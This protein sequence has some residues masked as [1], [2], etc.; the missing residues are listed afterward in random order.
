[1]TGLEADGAAVRTVFL[2]SGPFAV[3]ILDVLVDHRS[4]DLV[5]IVTSPPRPA[6]RRRTPT[7]TAVDLRARSLDLGPIL[8]PDRLRELDSVDDVLS[9]EPGLAVLADYGQLVPGALLRLSHGALNLHPS[10]LPRH[11]G[12]SP[13]PA[14]ILEGDRQTGVSLMLMDEDLDTGPILAQEVVPLTGT[15]TAPDLERTLAD[16]A[17]VLLAERL[18][19]WLRGEI[20]PAPQSDVGSTLTRPLRREDGRLD[21]TRP[22][23]RLERQ[24]RAYRPWPGS[25]VDSIAGRIGVWEAA[26]IEAAAEAR[27]GRL[28]RDGMTAGDGRRLRFLTVQP[29]GGRRMTW[30]ELLR[31]RPMLVGSDVVSG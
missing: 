22:A 2:G 16:V 7:P 28:D 24:V 27:P 10:L 15:E 1:V 17:A 9:L 25:F 4:V 21:P 3:P 18:G 5:G 29:A 20:T 8:T 6:G 23:V 12:A 14:A 26:D 30:D 11:R 13:I 19:P 31:G